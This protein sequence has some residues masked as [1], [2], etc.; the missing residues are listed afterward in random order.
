MNYPK[1]PETEKDVYEKEASIKVIKVLNQKSKFFL[2]ET[3]PYTTPI[4]LLYFSPIN[5]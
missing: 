5:T 2:K 4:T 1:N 3:N